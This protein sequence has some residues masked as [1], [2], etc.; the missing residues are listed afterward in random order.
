M[1]GVSISW[2]LS[3]SLTLSLCLCVMYSNNNAID[4]SVLLEL[5]LA[6]GSH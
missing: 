5:L 6:V 1:F 2:L 3:L 4:N